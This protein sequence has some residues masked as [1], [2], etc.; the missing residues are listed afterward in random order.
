MKLLRAIILL[1]I[2]LFFPLKS[3]TQIFSENRIKAEYIFLLAASVD[4]PD[5]IVANVYKIGVV[6]AN[7]IYTELS[8][9]SETDR[10]KGKPFNVEYFRRIKDIQPVH[11]LFLD[12]EMNT[13]IR[14]VWSKIKGQHVLLVTDSCQQYDYI[15]INLLALN[16]GGKPF[17]LNKQNVDDAGLQVSQQILYIGGR[18]DALREIYKISEEQLD[19]VKQELETRNEELENLNDELKLQYQQLDLRRREV[20]SL[21]RNIDDQKNELN[22][23]S[24]EIHSQQQSLQEKNEQLL[25]QEEDFIKLANEIKIKENQL[26]MQQDSIFAGR[27]ILLRQHDSIQLQKEEIQDQNLKIGE[28]RLVIA[29]QQYLLYFFLILLALVLIIVF[30][31]IRVNQVRR[32]A[33]RI[34]KERNDSIA[35]QHVEISRQKREILEQQKQ[36]EEINRAIEK[37]NEDIKASIYYALTIQNAILP[38]TGDIDS[39]FKNFSIYLPKDIVSG[40]FYWFSKAEKTDGNFDMFFFAVV[41]CTGHGV[42]GGFLS[43]IGSRMFST[44][45]NENHIYEP[46]QILDR[47][48]KNLR[49]ALKQDKTDNDDGMDVCFCRIDI[50]RNS[51]EIQNGQIRVLFTGAR[52]PLYY[53]KDQ[54]ELEMIKGC[55]KSVGGRYFHRRDHRSKLTIKGE[56]WNKEVDRYLIHDGEFINRRSEEIFRRGIVGIYEI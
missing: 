3:Y 11:I 13:S 40:D 18:E 42:P 36:L 24:A 9:K 23:L 31:V 7:K 48:D 46:D 21:T 50:E 27:Q 33:N 14:K 52:R 54:S 49:Q 55:R 17:E 8:F 12:K 30:F 29:R 39:Q 44:I 22:M 6:G 1:L 5:S 20:D 19:Q 10:F 25:K 26:R 28:Q 45:V 16:T 41:D 32:R 34:L 35:R 51:D 53:I 15:M 2:P 43:M 38:I 56:I 4:W 47:M 37:Q